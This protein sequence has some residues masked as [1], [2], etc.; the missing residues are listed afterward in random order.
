MLFQYIIKVKEDDRMA[1]FESIPYDVITKEKP[2]EIRAYNDVL[3]AA[4]KSTMNRRYDS[5]FMS[6]FNYISGQNDQS[7]KISMTTPVVSYEENDEL[8]TG[9]YVPKKYN[10]KTVP[11]PTSKNVFIDEMEQSLYGVITFRGS[12]TKSHFDQKENVLRS[13]LEKHHY[14]IISSRYIFRYQPPFIPGIF[15]RNEIAFKITKE[16]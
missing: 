11:L 14:K 15:R 2:I 16:I 4:T 9:F 5:G 10:K 8:V 12:W 7:Q 13:Y 3:L 6:V 1:I